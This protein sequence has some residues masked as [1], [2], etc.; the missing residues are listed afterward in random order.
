LISL[1]VTFADTAVA[2]RLCWDV[3]TGADTPVGEGE[4]EISREEAFAFAKDCLPSAIDIIC[5]N[6]WVEKYKVKFLCACPEH[7]LRAWCRVCDAQDEWR[8]KN[9]KNN[10][11]T[12]LA[13][14]SSSGTDHDRERD[15]RG[16]PDRLMF[17]LMQ[18]GFVASCSSAVTHA[19]RAY[20]RRPA[21]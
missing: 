19:T 5:D 13:A 21:S 18:F 12:L 9:Y 15:S 7:S 2:F 8:P 4:E 3:L 17:R 14:V 11:D 16:P 20:T 10:F 1:S 6:C